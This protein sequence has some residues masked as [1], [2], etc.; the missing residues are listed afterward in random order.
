MKTYTFNFLDAN[1]NV[2]TSKKAEFNNNSEAHDYAKKLFAN[3][4]IN[5]LKGIE[6]LREGFLM[7]VCEFVF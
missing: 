2:L 6:T 7:P 4:M 1:E 5:D 3:S